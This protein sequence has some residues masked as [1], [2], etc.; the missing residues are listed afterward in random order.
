[1]AAVSRT[2]RA[3]VAALPLRGGRPF[4]PRVLAKALPSGRALLLGFALLG[5][6]VLAY[7]GARETSVFSLRSVVVTGAPPQVAAH[8]RT[9]LKPLQG[10]SLLAFGRGEVERRLASLSDVARVSVNRDFPHTLR[11]E[12]TPAHSIVVLRRG[13]AA[14]IVSNDGRVIREAPRTAAPKLPRIWAPQEASVDV[15]GPISDSDAAEA[16]RAVAVARRAGFGIRIRAVRSTDGELTF[17][18]GSGLE[19]RL[20]D[21]TELPVKLAVARRILPLVDRASGYLD[22]GL[23]SRPISGDNSQVSS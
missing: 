17:V 19:L 10:R 14:W 13:S 22:V 23:P 21:M 1:M 4:G 20:G 8:V 16:L 18:L 11:L 12:V 15:G 2:G 7:I 9:A 3:P 6:G 5:G